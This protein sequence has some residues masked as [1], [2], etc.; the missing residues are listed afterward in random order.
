MT[1]FSPL[2]IILL[3]RLI[4]IM[5]NDTS[6]GAH[7]KNYKPSKRRY[8]MNL[9]FRRK[10]ENPGMLFNGHY[11]DVKAL[12]VLRTGNIPSIS[13]I[14]EVD[15]TKVFAYIKENLGADVK[16]T[17]QHSYFDHDSREAYFNNTIFIMPNKRMIELGNNYCHLL[18]ETDDYSWAYK[19]METLSN[20]RS[21]A[22]TTATTQ[23]LGF[24]RQAAMN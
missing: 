13:F 17:F 7:N 5:A 9:R 12:Y 19:L 18:Y 14:G 11:I 10:I 15:A 6:S 16:Q 4:L 1:T 21:V 8:K 24:A 20:F 2:L 22:G 3:V 23:V